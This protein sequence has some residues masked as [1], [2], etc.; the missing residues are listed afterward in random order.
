MTKKT[1]STPEQDLIRRLLKAVDAKE[2]ML[3]HYRAGSVR[4]PETLWKALDD[5]G[6]TVADAKDY[7]E[8]LDHD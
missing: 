3:S 5:A 8:R 6:P 4:I 1:K 2:R 7:L